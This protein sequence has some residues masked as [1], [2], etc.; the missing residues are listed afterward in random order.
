L[1]VAGIGDPGNY[2]SRDLRPGSPIPAT[3]RERR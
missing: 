2:E 3:T 1:A